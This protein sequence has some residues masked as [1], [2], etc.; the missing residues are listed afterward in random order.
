MTSFDNREDP[1][2]RWFLT[3]VT[4]ILVSLSAASWFLID[5]RMG[6]FAAGMWAQ[7]AY[8]SAGDAIKSWKEHR[9]APKKGADRR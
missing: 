3:G 1:E 2:D 5:Q 7:I 9:R 4:V 6:A 8:R